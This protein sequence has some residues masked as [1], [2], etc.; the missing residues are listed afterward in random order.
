MSNFEKQLMKIINKDKTQLSTFIKKKINSKFFQNK[1][2]KE[3][4]KLLPIIISNTNYYN[5][6]WLDIIYHMSSTGQFID[7]LIENINHLDFQNNE[8]L[9]FHILSQI[10]LLK[11]EENQL[12]KLINKILECNCEIHTMTIDEIYIIIKNNNPSLID[13]WF[14]AYLTNEKTCENTIKYISKNPQYINYIY[15]NIDFIL[16]HSKINTI[17]LFE[18]KN[19]TKENQEITTKVKNKIEETKKE[20]IQTTLENVYMRFLQNISLNQ[21]ELKKIETILEVV[22][23]IIEDISKNEQVQLS[24]LEILGSGTFSTAFILG[25]K[26]IKIGCKRGTKTFH[27]NPYVNAMLLRKEFP[28]NDDISFFVEV[29]EKLDTKNEVS[30]EELYQLYKKV[31]DIHLIWIDVAK[32]NVGR[33]LKENKV[34]WREELPITDERLGLQSYR[35]NAS[36][37]KGDAIIL[38]NDLIFDEND[39]IKIISEYSTPLQKKYEER[40]QHEKR[41]NSNEQFHS[42][43]NTINVEKELISKRK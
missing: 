25:D 43:Q 7:T 21:E 23:L 37:K 6:G 39:D 5:R 28:I 27:N 4:V 41:R 34:Y 33:L 22:Y 24:E 30:D 17:D 42:E 29:N 18:L 11:L 16:N 8:F 32:R 35:G 40:Y 13:E 26:V 20:S 3:L 31:R 12:T 19:I 15:Q 1:N 9:I 36:L 10:S 38:D 2:K 14:N